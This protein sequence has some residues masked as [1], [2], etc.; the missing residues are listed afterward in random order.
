[1]KKIVSV[2]ITM[3]LII[4]LVYLHFCADILDF[5]KFQ[6]ISNEER[7]QYSNRFYYNNLSEQQ[8]EIYL[9]YAKG[10]N[11]VNEKIRIKLNAALTGEQIG[12][13]INKAIE[14]YSY[15]YP[16][17]FYVESSYE[18]KIIDVLSSK[19]IEIYPQYINKE[20]I[21]S[22]KTE[23]QIE[24]DNIKSLY[25]E[26]DT[27]YH[28]ELV[29]HDYLVKNVQY[30][31]WENLEDIPDEMHTAYN[32]LV[33]KQAVCDGISKAFQIIMMQEG[34]ECITI[35]GNLDEIPH[36]WNVIKIDNEYYHVDLTS[37]QFKLNKKDMARLSHAFFNITDEEIKQTHDINRSYVYP[38]CKG[39]YNNFYYKENRVVT[40]NQNLRNKVKTIVNNIKYEELL[41][42]RVLN[43]GDVSDKLAQ[44]LYDIDFNKY[45]SNRAD[46]IGYTVTRDI[47]V[48]KIN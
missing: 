7:K 33:K 40:E 45:K 4:S 5:V 39:I 32:A 28:K 9:H 21:E 13:D 10:I 20:S 17:A 47:Y 18:M 30:Y 11:D 41:E 48:Y 1:M 8:K 14:A 12:E 19:I 15:D 34:I 46:S 31:S 2:I 3:S 36:A 24:I 29:V 27:E 35:T 38:E 6:E 42:V 43:R 37:D 23:M 25:K 22:M 26:S 16:E 44:I